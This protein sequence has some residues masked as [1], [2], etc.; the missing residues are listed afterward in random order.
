MLKSQAGQRPFDQIQAVNQFL[1]QWQYKT[2]EQNYGQRD[3]WAAPLE[4]LRRSGDCEDYA[5]VKYV[6]L[7]QLGFAAD[8]SAPG[9]V[10][11]RRRATCRTPCSRSISTAR[12]TSWTI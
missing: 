3:Y 5:I 9:G 11:R 10:A 2:D 12:S 6:S 4:F 1:N 7:R 8:R